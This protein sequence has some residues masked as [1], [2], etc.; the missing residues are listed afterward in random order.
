MDNAKPMQILIVDDELSMRTRLA[1][2]LRAEGYEV[3]TAA[4]GLA[5]VE[6][7]PRK[8]YEVILM[9]VRIPGLDGVEAFRRIRRHREGVR[10]FLMSA[11][12]VDD[13]KQLALAE[14]VVA[15]LDKPLDIDKVIWLI[16]ES[17]ETTILVVADDADTATTLSQALTTQGYHVTVVQS[18]HAA[19]ELIEQ[20]RFDILF[21]D[22]QL[23]AMNGLDLYLAIKRITSTTIAIMITGMNAE[24][25]RLAHE[26]V[27][28]T[29]Y[30]F[31][32]KPLDVD[33]LLGLLARLKRQRISDALRKPSEER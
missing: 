2:I 6:P 14:G 23:P 22:V 25:E 12:G 30:T 28:Q 11:Y 24:F 19:L 32:R 10:V 27:R 13:L 29:A 16:Q 4:D 8:S 21:I 7:C 26:A 31:V 15:F 9:D 1:A 33:H 20:I 17:Q 3:D 5:A 18:P